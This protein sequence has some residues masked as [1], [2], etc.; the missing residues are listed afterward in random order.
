M[1]HGA[2]GKVQQFTQPDEN[3][4]A[5]N[6]AKE[7]N[8]QL[9]MR[10]A[11]HIKK[12][13]TQRKLYRLCTAN[14]ITSAQQ[15]TTSHSDMVYTFVVDYG[16]NMDMPAFNSMQPGETCYY[17]PLTVYNLGVVNTAEVLSNDMEPEEHLHAHQR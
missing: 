6:D 9:L 1:V 15:K 16:Q 12:A 2:S 3:E 11:Y 4:K 13:R 7:S 17:S 5:T 10:A 14:A 8:E